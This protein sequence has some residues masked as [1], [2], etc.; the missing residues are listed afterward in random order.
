M[1]NKKWKARSLALSFL[2]VFLIPYRDYLIRTIICK[3]SFAFCWQVSQ[4]RVSCM[5][6]NLF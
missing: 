3:Q 1:L 4:A 6:I 2:R 5:A